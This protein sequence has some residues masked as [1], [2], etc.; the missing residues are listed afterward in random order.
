[1]CDL[2][3]VVTYVYGSV[4][5]FFSLSQHNIEKHDSLITFIGHHMD[6]RAVCCQ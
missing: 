2:Q 1:M 4:E 3:M 6:Y 5:T